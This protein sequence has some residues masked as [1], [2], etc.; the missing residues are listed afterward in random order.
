[1]AAVETTNTE[2]AWLQ[3]F[4][5]TPLKI[6]G[7]ITACR[8]YLKMKMRGV[9]V[10]EQIQWILSYI[11]RG[12]ADMWKENMLEDLETGVLEYETVGK[13]LVDIRK[14]FGGRDKESAKVAELKK[15]E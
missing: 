12:L 11:Q 7:F 8:L 5:R 3:V 1:V 6:S 2:V 13:F 9:V 15:L 10:E 4:D 14:K